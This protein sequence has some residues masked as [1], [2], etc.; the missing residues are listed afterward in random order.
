MER[1]L[2]FS[3]PHHQQGRLAS[4]GGLRHEVACTR[5]QVLAAWRLVHASYRERKLIEEQPEGV[6]VC[7]QAI[8]PHAAVMLGL[9]GPVTVTTLTAVIDRGQG[10]P[11]DRVYGPEMTAMRRLGRV[12]MQAGLFADRRQL[13]TRY[14]SALFDQMRMAYHFALHEGVTDIVI[15]VNPEHGPF[16][17][18]AFAMEYVG[19]TR[20]DPRLNHIPVVLLHSR[21]DGGGDGD[22]SDGP[23]TPAIRYFRNNPIEASFYAG[24]F[25]FAARSLAGSPLE[26]YVQACGGVSAGMF[27]T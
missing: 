2:A 21:L 10:L 1:L 14:E 9:M 13:I 12:I 3:Q 22:S 18:R 16:Y 19:V 5:E 8:N 17:C 23:A 4:P 11:V 6:Y 25:D 24:R 20:C 7:P 15:A 26:R 27:I